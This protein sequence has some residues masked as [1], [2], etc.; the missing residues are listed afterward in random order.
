MRMLIGMLVTIGIVLAPIPVVIFDG[1]LSKAE[2]RKDSC[3]RTNRATHQRFRI[4]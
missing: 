3:W 2:A 1:T 4:C